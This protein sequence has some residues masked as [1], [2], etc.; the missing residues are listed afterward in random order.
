VKQF[1]LTRIK[2]GRH[3]R[4][5]IKAID[6][7]LQEHLDRWSQEYLDVLTDLV[8][9]YEDQHV[10]IPDASEADVLRELMRSNGLTQAQLSKQI[11]IAQS[12]ISAVLTGDRSLTRAQVIKLAKFF[13]VSPAAFMPA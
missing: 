5:A 7:L 6:R 9:A 3:L 4:A 8:E 1:P 13:N 2:D 11:D 12:T 10:V